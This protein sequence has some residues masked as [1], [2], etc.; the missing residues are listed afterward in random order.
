[1]KS[2]NQLSI[3]GNVGADPEVRST[4]SGGRVAS[5]SVATSRQWAN[6]AGAK[7]EKTEWHR[8]VAWNFGKQ[9]LADVV[10]KYVRKG[11]RVFVQGRLEFREWNDKDGNK[12]FA[13]ELNA[14]DVLML[15]NKRDVTP[16]AARMT[17]AD[18]IESPSDVDD[19]DLPF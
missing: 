11:D 6:A 15:G 3:I 7:Q 12:H 2:L 18:A 4:T 13:A 17:K 16:S 1:M 9:T 14:R 5:F 8:V 19:D 10:E